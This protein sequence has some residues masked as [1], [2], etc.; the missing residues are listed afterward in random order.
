MR[1]PVLKQECPHAPG[2]TGSSWLETCFAEKDLEVLVN[3]E[4]ASVPMW[5]SCKQGCIR[6]GTGKKS[7]EGVLPFYPAVVGLHLKYQVQ[8]QLPQNKEVIDVLD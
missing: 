1:T 6:K 8:L 2:Q 3:T 7:R 4:P 5:Q